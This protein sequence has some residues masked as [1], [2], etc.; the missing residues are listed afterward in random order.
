MFYVDGANMTFYCMSSGVAL[1]YYGFTTA[2]SVNT[3]YHVALVRNGTDVKVY[4]NGTAVT[5][6]VTVAI[7]TAS[8]PNFTRTAY[9][10]MRDR[11]GTLDRPFS[12]WIDEYRFSKGIARWTA[13]FT[14][15]ITEYSTSV[16]DELDNS[17][18]G[19]ALTTQQS[20]R[21]ICDGTEWWSVHP[22]IHDLL[23]LWHSDTLADSVAAGDILI[24]NATPKWARLAKGTAL[25][26][27]AMNSDGTLPEWVEVTGSGKVVRDTSP[28][29]VTPDIGAA[30]G[31]SL[32]LVS[33][34]AGAQTTPLNV[35][36]GSSTAATEVMLRLFASSHAARYAAVSALQRGSELIDLVFY[37]CYG[38]TPAERM[39]IDHAGIVAIGTADIE[40]WSSA[41]TPIHIGGNGSVSA[42]TE[43]GAGG[44]FNL[45]QNAYYD[46]QWRYRSADEASNYYQQNGT[47]VFRVVASGSVDNVITW[48][49][50]LTLDNSGNTVVAK[51]LDLSGASAGQIKFPASQNASADA[52]TLDDYEEGTW[53][54]VLAFGGA[55]VDLTYFAQAGSYTKIGDRVTITGYI[56]VNSKGTSTGAATITGLPFTCYNNDNAQ[57]AVS[58]FLNTVSFSDNFEGY[59]TKNTAIINLNDVGVT[60]AVGTLSNAD[61]GSW[62]EVRL[63][64]TYK[65]A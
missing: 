46:G 8:L 26:V 55:S 53:T 59:I 43:V 11:G 12:G 22:S 14:V 29:L 9:I 44:I 61:F 47:H 40:A 21:V 51:L 52:N 23:S 57:N 15:P 6:T 63:R 27:L 45:N 16:Y 36:N 5:R 34:S 35:Y 30:T 1:A 49:T 54:P 38:D 17:Q 13:N 65:V 42:N 24:G 28:A 4:K 50:A 18:T 25:Y 60:G 37:T 10:G 64:V 31:T 41:H 2:F 62:S 56:A 58:L 7:S 39:R 19:I 32:D 20:L 48:V 3:W 33:T